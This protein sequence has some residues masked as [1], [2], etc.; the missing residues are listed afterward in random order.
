M[1]EIALDPRHLETVR[2]I[3]RKHVP[4]AEVRAFGSRVTGGARK[5]SDLD[6]ALVGPS[7]VE[8][9]RMGRLAAALSESDLPI[10]VDVLD[11]HG[12]SA[13]F[14]RVIDQKFVVLQE[15]NS[16]GAEAGGAAS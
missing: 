4:E 16:P 9:S 15:G 12:I 13:A 10:R 8:W 3:I 11:W 1:P 7:E 6:L 14:R 2:R 5:Y